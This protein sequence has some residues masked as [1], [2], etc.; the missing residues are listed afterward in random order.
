MAPG[1]VVRT[2]DP[3]DRPAACRALFAYRPEP[4]RDRRAARALHLLNSGEFDPDGLLVA[5]ADGRV[6]GAALAQH[7][8][9]SAAVAWPPGAEPGPGQD[10]IVAA[11]ARAV[12]DRLHAAGV[13]Q[14]QALLP[15][16][17]RDRAR[18]L[19]AVGF[20]HITRL[21]FLCRPVPAGGFDADGSPLRFTPADGPAFA[22]TLFATYDGTLDCPELNGTRTPDEVLAGYRAAAAD[23]PD[24]W[25]ASDGP[26][27][28]GVVLLAPGPRPGVVE[29]SYLGLVP[30]ARGRGLGRE[31]VRHALARAAAS[32]AEWLTLSADVRNEPALRVYRAHGFREYD[33]QDVFLWHPVS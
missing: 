12:A 23:P 18:P 2:A 22:D 20:R 25:L 24:W 1:P 16:A 13:K 19:E 15:P 27:P 6:V 3:A 30:S 4:E 21:T 26:G 9:G 8:P 17:D 7:H 29:L 28:A 33:L 14:A 10:V 31:L 11:L 5:W 32:A